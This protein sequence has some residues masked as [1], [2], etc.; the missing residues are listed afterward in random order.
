MPVVLMSWVVIS[1]PVCGDFGIGF[2]VYHKI[3]LCQAISLISA[4]AQ[5]EMAW[6]H[7]HPKDARSTLPFHFNL[8]FFKIV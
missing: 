4:P 6:C 2:Y 7:K 3:S 1:P 5:F 8:Y